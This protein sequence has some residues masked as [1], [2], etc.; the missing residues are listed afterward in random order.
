MKRNVSVADA[1]AVLDE[2]EALQ[3][4]LHLQQTEYN[5]TYTTHQ[6]NCVNVNS[7]VAIPLWDCHRSKKNKATV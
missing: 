1:S 3:L 2:L 6:P 5:Y 7:G 4:M